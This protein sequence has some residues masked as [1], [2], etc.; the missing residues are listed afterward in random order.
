[1]MLLMMISGNT[2]RH[3]KAVHVLRFKVPMA[4]PL[5]LIAPDRMRRVIAEGVSASLGLQP[6]A[7][8]VVEATIHRRFDIDGRPLAC[9]TSSIALEIVATADSGVFSTQQLAKDVTTACTEGS[10][11]VYVQA[12]AARN[13][14]LTKCFKG[15]PNILSIPITQEADVVRP[16]TKNVAAYHD[17]TPLDESIA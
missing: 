3:F 12:T 10:L 4:L 14:L 1:M 13:G 11:I 16:V 9:P 7:V 8:G 5:E 15:Q 6:S 17:R 2:F